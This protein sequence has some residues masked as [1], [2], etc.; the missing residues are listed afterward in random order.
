M[1]RLKVM[2]IFSLFFSLT[3]LAEQ[4]IELLSLDEAIRIALE[5]NPNIMASDASV[6]IMRARLQ[7]SKS[8]L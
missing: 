7:D 5:N 3:A 6:D 4:D 2:F 8:I 1:K